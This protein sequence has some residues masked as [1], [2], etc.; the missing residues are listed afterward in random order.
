MYKFTRIDDDTTEL[1]YN[2]EKFT[3]VKDL[4]KAVQ[5]QQV[6]FEARVLLNKKLKEMG[7]TIE[8]LQYEK[9]EGG[10]KIIDDKQVQ[11]LL[12][13]CKQMATYNKMKQLVKDIIG[14]NLLDLAI[15]LGKDD[16]EKFMVELGKAITGTSEKTPSK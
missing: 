15:E 3:I 9:V 1:E 4:E 16:Y 12:D 14:K 11:I 13:D 10:K 6:D 8:D 5:L 7:Q 2:G